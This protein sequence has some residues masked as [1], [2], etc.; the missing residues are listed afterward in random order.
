M[1]ATLADAAPLRRGSNLQAWE[2]HVLGWLRLWF[3][4]RAFACQGKD[5]VA[6]SA[7]SG[8]VG[9]GSGGGCRC[10][11]HQVGAL[12]MTFRPRAAHVVPFRPV[13]VESAP[14]RPPQLANGSDEIPPHHRFRRLF[15][16]AAS[17]TPGAG[18][19]LEGAALP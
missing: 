16:A 10:L 3:R 17:L 4:R 9:A 14:E 8:E 11:G 5:G 18:A 7:Q 13:S 2:A 15:R 6:L 12:G 19:I 1:S